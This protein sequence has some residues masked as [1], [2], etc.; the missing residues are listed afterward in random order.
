MTLFGKIL[1]VL[2][3]LA[4]VAFLV[5]ML[6]VTGQRNA[7]EYTTFLHGKVPTGTPVDKEQPDVADDA[8][9]D[10]LFRPARDKLADVIETSKEDE[11]Q[12][13]QRL[14]RTLQ[15]WARPGQAGK[16]ADELR[17]AQGGTRELVTDLRRPLSK[18][19][20]LKK[21]RPLLVVKTQQEEVQ[22]WHDYLVADLNARGDEAAKRQRLAEI[23]VPMAATLNER[24]ELMQKCKTAPLDELLGPSGPFEMAFRP[25]LA[26]TENTAGK[27]Q[28]I[29][30]L[31]FSLAQIRGPDGQL[32]DPS[33]STRAA[34]VIG[35]R[36]Y[37]QAAAL[38]ARQL[39]DMA[40]E[41][42][43]QMYYG[44]NSERARFV[45]QH[46]AILDELK[47]MAVEIGDR[48][49][50][51]AQLDAEKARLQDQIKARTLVVQEYTDKLKKAGTEVTADRARQAELEKQLFQALLDLAR[52]GDQNLALEREI[53]RLEGLR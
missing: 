4:A 20:Q 53:R 44:P 1:L 41:V 21:V 39:Q 12:K 40:A 16:V 15:S 10:D 28:T 34:L 25:A 37:N 52:A 23:L 13:K 27:G 38:H 32:E 6:L 31:L 22:R 3:L 9:L 17:A 47:L 30:G 19:Q 2:N 45:N 5:L 24:I 46:H 35:L 49:Y 51:L 29:A 7:W 11:G 48:K 36:E 18:S 42:R 43:Q 26:P 50:T 14:E 33:A 8:V